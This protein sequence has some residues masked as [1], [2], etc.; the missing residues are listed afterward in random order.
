MSREIVIFT[1]F[2]IITL[3]QVFYYLIFLSEAGFLQ[4]KTKK[5]FPNSSGFGN[6][7]FKGRSGKFGKKSSGRTGAELSDDSR[8]DRGER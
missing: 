5:Y 2:C 4:I 1:G 7:L 8:G 6:Y 3:I